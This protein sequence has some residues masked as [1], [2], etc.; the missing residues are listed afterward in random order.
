MQPSTTYSGVAHR[1]GD[2]ASLIEALDHAAEGACGLNFYGT[3][4]TLTATLSYAELR[5]RAIGLAGRLAAVYPRHARIGLIAETTPEFMVA[6]MAC[7]YAGLVPAPL[8]VQ[9]AFGRREVYEWQISRTAQTADLAAVMA[10]DE[11]AEVLRAALAEVDIPLIAICGRDLPETGVVPVPHGKDDP[12][13]IQFSSGSTSAPKGIYATQ[14]SVSA[15]CHAIINEALHMTAEDRCVSWLPLYHD[16]GLVGFFM[17]PLYNQTTVDYISPT[18]FARRP[19]SWLKLVSE[20]RGTIVYSPSFGYDLCARRYRGET[21]DLGSLRVAGIGGDMVRE[22]ALVSFTDIFGP[23]GFDGRAFVP[24]YGLA[25]STLGVA[26]APLDT[27]MKRDLVD[28]GRMQTSGRAVPAT[29]QTRPGQTRCFVSCGRPL[30]SFEMRIVDTD[31]REIQGRDIGRIMIKSPSIADGYFRAGEP[32]QPLTDADGWMETGDLGY[33]LEGEV[34]ITGRSKDLILWNG[35]NIWPQDIEWV[36][37]NT[38]GKNIS[39]A[40]AFEVGDTDGGSRIVLLAECWSRDEAVRAQLIRDI[41][42]ATRATTGAPVS[43]ELVGVRSL[44]MTSSGKLSRAAARA[45]YLAGDY[46]SSTPADERVTAAAP[47]RGA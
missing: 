3:D 6:F 24:S 30:P 38:G 31:G 26:F 12:A 8:T 40:G 39:G 2:F 22:D 28:T 35:R 4:A 44:P 29:P 16:M 32:L 15:N 36:A 41:S 14:K 18:S 9:A 13:Y 11:V 27:G 17:V 45:R 42:A 21:L 1:P 46:A 34:V 19:I 25:E 43:V 23:S 33:W 5:T 7:Q 47:A 37:Q 20:N 10:T